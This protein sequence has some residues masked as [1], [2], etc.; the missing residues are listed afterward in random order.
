MELQYYRTSKIELR[1][2]VAKIKKPFQS[3]SIKYR[4]L[5]FFIVGYV[6]I[7]H[8]CSS[9]EGNGEDCLPDH[10]GLG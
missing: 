1:E 7:K 6:G 3:K 9:V 8:D 2:T 10:K 5:P 4:V